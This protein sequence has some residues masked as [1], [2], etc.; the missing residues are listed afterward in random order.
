VSEV[1][2][3]APDVVRVTDK[4]PWNFLFAG[5]IDLLLPNARI[6]HCVRDPLDTCLSLF[7]TSFASLPFTNDLVDI[8]AYYNAYTSL[9]QHWRSVLPGGRILD[10][11]YEDMVGDLETQARR[12]VAHC[13]LPWDDGCIE[14]QGVNRAVNTASLVQVRQPLY[15]NSVARWRRYERHL[16]PLRAEL[17]ENVSWQ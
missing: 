10:V 16:D 12:I 6:I 2:V 11:R 1:R 15:S 8:G 3:L 9:M 7:T 17:G 4:L 13:G 14:F 5:L